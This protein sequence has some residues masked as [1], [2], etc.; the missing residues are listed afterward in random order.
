MTA[1]R[2]SL[3]TG[4]V[5]G[6][7]LSALASILVFAS[8]AS[9]D[10]FK[11]YYNA[12]LG[13]S[14]YLTYPA[15][16]NAKAKIGPINVWRIQ[17]IS[18]SP[19]NHDRVYLKTYS[20][21]RCLDSHAGNVGNAAWVISCNGGDYQIWEVFYQANGS[22]VFKSWG[23]WTQDGRHLCITSSSDPTVVN[24]ATCNESYTRQQ[25]YGATAPGNP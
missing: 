13:P 10:S 19:S 12:Y 23:S 9:A 17:Q 22:R 15:S 24:L 20:D 25:W 18:D 7:V 16:G 21:N 11:T 2:A 4:L 1:G 3:R 6:A 14:H 8:P 5:L